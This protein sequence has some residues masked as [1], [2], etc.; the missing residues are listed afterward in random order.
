M[1]YVLLIYCIRLESKSIMFLSSIIED[2]FTLLL[3]L[4]CFRYNQIP[5]TIV[6][7]YTQKYSSL[8][9]NK[10]SNACTSLY[11]K[12]IDSGKKALHF[13]YF[14]NIIRLVYNM[15]DFKCSVIFVCNLPKF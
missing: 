4:I 7:F 14:N 12:L 5:I 8:L 13:L 1:K 2:F 15:N 11:L 3:Y 9:D 10:K 6:L